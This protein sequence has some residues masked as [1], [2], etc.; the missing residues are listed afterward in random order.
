MI[1]YYTHEQFYFGIGELVR[2]GLQFDADHDELTIK[3]SGVL[4]L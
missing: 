3:L 1:T 2:M 4:G